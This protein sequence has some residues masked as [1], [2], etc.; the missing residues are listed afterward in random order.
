MTEIS[1]H[2][3]IWADKL[4]KALV[5]LLSLSSIVPMFLILFMIT[6][7]GISVIDWQF[8]S[9]LPKPVGE[10]GG[11]ISNAILGTLWLI[12]LSFLFS[13]P[14]GILPGFSSRNT[15]EGSWPI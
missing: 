1:I 5:I 7:N 3:R 9:H 2:R 14:L 10:A 13:V 8:L 4:F 15:K 11:G 6:Q 12:G